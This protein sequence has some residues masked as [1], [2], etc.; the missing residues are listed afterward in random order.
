[1]MYY[2]QLLPAIFLIQKVGMGFFLSCVHI[3]LGLGA[4]WPDLGN[5]GMAESE[6]ASPESKNS[7]SQPHYTDPLP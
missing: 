6:Q 2:L 1:M 4:T 3:D 7:T 5:T